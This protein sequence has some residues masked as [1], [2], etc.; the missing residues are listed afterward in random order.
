MNFSAAQFLHSSP[1][2]QVGGLNRLQDRRR[3]AALQSTVDGRQ[4][5][6]VEQE[7]YTIIRRCIRLSR[8]SCRQHHLTGNI[9]NGDDNLDCV[10]ILSDESSVR[11]LGFID[12]PRVTKNLETLKQNFIR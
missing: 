10:S 8:K 1:L 2:G 6:L 7:D 5:P 12:D 11:Q 9:N 4:C 3:S